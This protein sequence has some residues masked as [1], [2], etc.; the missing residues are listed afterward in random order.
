MDIIRT[1][2]WNSLLLDG[3]LL[4]LTGCA[5]VSLT[6]ILTGYWRRV[7]I[8]ETE[9]ALKSKMIDKGYSAAEMERVCKLQLDSAPRN[10]SKRRDI[11]QP[12][13]V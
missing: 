10:R 12:A 9:A 5:I 7:R 4:P 11:D 3:P 1:I 6:F 8:A 2:D 13:Y